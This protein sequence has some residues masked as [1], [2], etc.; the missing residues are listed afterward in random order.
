MRRSLCCMD[1]EGVV[2]HEAV[3]NFEPPLRER[4]VITGGTLG[5]A[6]CISKSI[7]AGVE[8]V[9]EPSVP[10]AIFPAVPQGCPVAITCKQTC[11]CGTREWKHHRRERE[12]KVREDAEWCCTGLFQ[13]RLYLFHRN[14]DIQL[15]L[16]AWPRGSLAIYIQL[17]SQTPSS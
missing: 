15:P 12:Y 9:R 16:C 17:L 7:D 6:P 5:Q 14:C 4:E 13:S 11:R 2:L 8:E 1:A 3:D 10:M